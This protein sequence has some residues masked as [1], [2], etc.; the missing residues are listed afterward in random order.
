M[1]VVYIQVQVQPKRIAITCQ[2]PAVLQNCF[3]VDRVYVEQQ[4][5][6]FSVLKLFLKALTICYQDE[7]VNFF[8][9][10]NIH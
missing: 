3:S 1:A 4:T 9:D 10:K 7:V 8:Y 6:I 5:D 2:L